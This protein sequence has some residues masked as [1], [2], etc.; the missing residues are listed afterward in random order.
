M[1]ERNLRFDTHE[2]LTGYGL[3]MDIDSIIEKVLRIEI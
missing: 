1:N 2:V 3:Y